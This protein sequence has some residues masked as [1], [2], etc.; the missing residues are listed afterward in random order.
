MELV[1]LVG[2]QA[3][4]KTSFYGRHFADTHMHVSKDLMRN[5]RNRQARQLALIEQALSRGRSVVVD[6][7]NPRVEDRAPLI[8]LGKAS[9]ARIAGYGFEASVSECMRRNAAREGRARVPE[10]AIHST[11]RKLEHPTAIEGFDAL[12]QVRLC[13]GG[14][15][16]DP[17]A[18]LPQECPDFALEA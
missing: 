15:E 13:E 18:N 11:A 4:G 16:I 5:A 12:Y 7:T 8:R 10:I 9:G 1:I 6:N 17:A 14:F 2:L 3:S